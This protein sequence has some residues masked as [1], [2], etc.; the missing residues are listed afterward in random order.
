MDDDV[1]ADFAAY[2]RS[3]G[4]SPRTIGNRDYILRATANATGVSLLTMTTRDL[5]GRL[6]RGVQVGT[7]TTERD[8]FVA[9]YRF[10]VREE[11]RTDDPCNR[12]DP[13][14]RTR[15]EPR[16]Y[17]QQQID[18]LL[19]T[20][21]YRRTR[22]M[23]LLAYH[24]GLRAASIA[25]I[26][27]HDF[28]L[29]N[30]TIRIVAKGDKIAVRPLHPIIRELAQTMPRDGYWFPARNGAPGHIHPRSVY[31][32]MTRAKKRA[33]IHDTRLTGHSLRHA[34]ATELV[35]AD[36]DIAVVSK[37]MMHSSLA[38]TSIYAGVSSRRL[39]EGV[40][41]LPSKALPPISGRR[42]AA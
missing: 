1:L 22:V 6:G 32:L 4:L 3:K 14:R 41:A 33:G 25:R 26:H 37:L 31:D 15:G 36:V 34:F 2:Q 13:I 17:T 40:T 19:T 29:E 7:M 10:A 20:G 35:E 16:P 30:D 5:R 28:D 11:Y 12:L 38:T 8:T 21:S 42:R 27:G 9:F 18:L 24:Q 39:R 23:I